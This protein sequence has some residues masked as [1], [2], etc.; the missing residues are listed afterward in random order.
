MPMTY[1]SL[2]Q[3]IILNAQ[4]T[5]VE[6]V[7][8]VPNFIER[9]ITR[10]YTEADDLGLEIFT[11][12][13]A[14]NFRLSANRA[15]VQKRPNWKKTLSLSYIDPIS[16]EA[17]FLLPRSYEAALAY[18]PN[19]AIAATPL[20]YSDRSAPS[21]DEQ[22]NNPYLFFYITPT[23]NITANLNHVWVGVPIFSPEVPTNF[24]TQRYPSILFYGCMSEAMTYLKDD[25]RI[26]TF[27][28][29]YSAALG[30]TN[31]QNQ[32]AYADRTTKREEGS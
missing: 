29:L 7:G 18:A 17:H 10:I 21:N 26:A 11:E 15:I 16:N 13:N 12:E 1:Q 25:Q 22:P 5:D 6:F 20:F 32:E 24:L 9:A 27:E 8:Q 30:R 28:K 31:T 2:T 4:R 14:D 19:P 23:P 3:D